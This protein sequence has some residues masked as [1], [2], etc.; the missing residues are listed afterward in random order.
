MLIGLIVGYDNSLAAL[1]SKTCDARGYEM[2]PVK[3]KESDASLQFLGKGVCS[4]TPSEV[5]GSLHHTL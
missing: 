3:V 4:D 2:N 5:K 1:L